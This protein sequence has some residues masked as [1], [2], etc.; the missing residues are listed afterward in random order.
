MNEVNSIKGFF[1][2]PLISSNFMLIYCPAIN[3]QSAIQMT[4]GNEE[5]SVMGLSLRSAAGWMA[6]WVGGWRGG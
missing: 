5:A 6:G 1:P 3:T 2:L 4:R